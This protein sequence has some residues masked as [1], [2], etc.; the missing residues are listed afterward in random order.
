MTKYLRHL[1]SSH[2]NFRSQRSTVESYV[3]I[4]DASFHCLFFRISQIVLKNYIFREF[5]NQKHARMCKF[6][7]WPLIALDSGKRTRTRFNFKFSPRLFSKNRHHGKL[8]CTC[9][10]HKS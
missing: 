1:T 10:H 9:I 6:L 4:A 8:H 3:C 5:V 2:V 7:V